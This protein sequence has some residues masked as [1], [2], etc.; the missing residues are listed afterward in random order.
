MIEQF[1][2]SCLY[3]RR[4]RGSRICRALGLGFSV[5]EFKALGPGIGDQGQDEDLG[6]GIEG[7]V[8]FAYRGGRAHV[9]GLGFR[10]LVSGFPFQRSKV[11]LGVRNNVEV[12]RR[13]CEIRTRR[14]LWSPIE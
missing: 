5:D 14:P 9:R 8:G 13:N 6:F 4:N 10:V 1:V 12:S 11:R 2:R 3:K 7:L